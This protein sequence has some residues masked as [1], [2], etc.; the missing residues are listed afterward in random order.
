MELIKTIV[1]ERGCFIQKISLRKTFSNLK[2]V[3]FCGKIYAFGLDLMRNISTFLS[4]APYFL[5]G[6][7]WVC[8]VLL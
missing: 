6:L 2:E 7:G 3:T 5:I 8:L 4:T 1:H